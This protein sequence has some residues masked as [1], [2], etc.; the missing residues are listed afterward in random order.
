MGSAA[1]NM[2]PTLTTTATYITQK[3]L[4]H[5]YCSNDTVDRE[6]QIEHQYLTNSTAKIR[7][8]DIFSGI[9]RYTFHF[10][11]DL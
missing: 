11:I 9:T 2:M 5:A 3:F 1:N 6:Y 4:D 10:M 8:F 7:Y